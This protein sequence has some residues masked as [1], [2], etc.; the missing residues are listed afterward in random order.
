MDFAVA[1]VSAA[2]YFHD[3]LWYMGRYS[4]F[5]HPNSVCM[6]YFEHMSLSLGFSKTLMGAS[7]K[8]LVHAFVPSMYITSTS[9]TQ[10]KLRRQLTEAG[11]ERRHE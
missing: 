2:L 9:D 10:K 5:T 11:C 4:F 6:T 8:S 7:W 1:S 3:H